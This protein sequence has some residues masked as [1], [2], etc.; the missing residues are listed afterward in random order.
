MSYYFIYYCFFVV[1]AVIIYQSINQS[2]IFYYYHYLL[3]F[4]NQ[5]IIEQAVNFITII[6]VCFLISGTYIQDHQIVTLV[7]LVN[8]VSTGLAH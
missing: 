2:M 7:F 5:S 4:V 8:L 1:V 6:T 3:L